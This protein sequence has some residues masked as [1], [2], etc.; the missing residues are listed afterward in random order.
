M[1]VDDVSD[2]TEAV[3]TQMLNVFKAISEEVMATKEAPELGENK[4]DWIFL[5]QKII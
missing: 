3:R 1:T 2:F 5:L 4:V